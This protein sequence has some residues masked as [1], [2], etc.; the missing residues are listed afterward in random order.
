MC[1]FMTL[2]ENCSFN[3]SLSTMSW[4]HK[5]IIH[6]GV[7]NIYCWFE[8]GSSGHLSK[9]HLQIVSQYYYTYIKQ[10]LL[11]MPN[12]NNS[13]HFTY[14]TKPAEIVH[15][16]KRLLTELAKTV[17]QTIQNT[18]RNL[19]SYISHFPLFNMHSH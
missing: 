18:S 8:Y 9:G 5:N 7:D 10:T 13:R 3:L 16:N 11:Q 2:I 1:L 15:N 19:L 17:I 12:F 4:A 6:S 14:L